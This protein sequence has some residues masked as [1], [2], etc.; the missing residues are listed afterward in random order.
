M[1]QSYFSSNKNYII[2]TL[3]MNTLPTIIS[4]LSSDK[5]FSVFIHTENSTGENF[6]EN[7]LGIGAEKLQY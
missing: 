1:T 7:S 5:W 6:F 2:Q 3:A 4:P